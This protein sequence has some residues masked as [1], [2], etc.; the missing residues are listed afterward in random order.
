MADFENS[1]LAKRRHVEHGLW[2][3]H[4]PARFDSRPDGRRAETRW[5]ITR[6]MP[7]EGDGRGAAIDH[8]Y[9]PTEP[10]VAAGFG[11]ARSPSAQAVAAAADIIKISVFEE[12]RRAAMID[13]RRKIV[14]GGG[15]R[16][17]I[18]YDHAVSR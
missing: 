3:G 1:H 9:M 2:P 15:Y 13:S 8:G 10:A 17:A 16:G 18:V 7:R 6:H 4:A 14:V 11:W 12:R 5:P